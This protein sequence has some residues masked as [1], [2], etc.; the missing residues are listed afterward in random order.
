V[1][2]PTPIA[3][4]SRL[5]RLQIG[6]DAEPGVLTSWCAGSRCQTDTAKPSRYLKGTPDGVL[7]FQTAS[8]P[9][10]AS[11]VITKRG[12]SVP[13]KQGALIP[14]TLMAFPAVLPRGRYLV[15][16]RA[17]WRGIDAKWVFGLSG[18]VGS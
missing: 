10:T 8:Q 6:S 4:P 2:S 13:S 5:A 15:T 18:P 14:G 16:L 11:A 9:L 3:G 1:I 17:H 12:G 7:L